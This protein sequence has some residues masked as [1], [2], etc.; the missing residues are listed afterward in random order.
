MASNSIFNQHVMRDFEKLKKF[1]RN[2]IAP[3]VWLCFGLPSGAAT[4]TE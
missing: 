2:N 1:S 3:V 4:C